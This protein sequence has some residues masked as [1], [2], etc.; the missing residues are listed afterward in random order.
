M[1]YEDCDLAVSGKRTL[2]EGVADRTWNLLL[3]VDKGDLICYKSIK[4]DYCNLSR[5]ASIRSTC[6]RRKQLAMILSKRPDLAAACSRYNAAMGGAAIL[7]R[8]EYFQPFYSVD[9][10]PCTT[11]F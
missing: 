1:V 5:A 9:L 10:H 2:I 6:T 11:T 8:S 3:Y 7:E 4:V